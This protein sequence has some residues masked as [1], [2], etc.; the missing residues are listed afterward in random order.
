MACLAA[1]RW[2]NRLVALFGLYESG[3][4]GFQRVGSIS[5]CRPSL[6]QVCFADG[7]C[8]DLLQ[9][10]RLSPPAVGAEG[11]G[12]RGRIVSLA[13]LLSQSGYQVPAQVER[14][15][16]VAKEVVPERIALPSLAG[17]FDPADHLSEPFRTMYLDVSGQRK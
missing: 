8:A 12:Q 6:K 10:C 16:S 3:A 15:C 5:R 11:S 17:G 13:R 2:T 7:L 1:R 14:T 4:Q 9:W